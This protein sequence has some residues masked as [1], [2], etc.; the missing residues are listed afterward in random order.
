MSDTTLSG[1]VDAALSEVM[2]A[3]RSGDGERVRAATKQARDAGASTDEIDVALGIV[4]SSPDEYYRPP[5]MSDEEYERRYKETRTV[6]AGVPQW[7]PGGDPL[8]KM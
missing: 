5:G 1:L 2:E 7:S 6:V 3:N 4:Y 8:G